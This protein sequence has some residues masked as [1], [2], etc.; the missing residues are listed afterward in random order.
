MAVSTQFLGWD[1]PVIRKVVAFL[2]PAEMTGL[3]DLSGDLIVVPTRQAGRRLREALAVECAKRDT[4]VMSVRV[5]THNALLHMDPIDQPMANDCLVRAVW[6][7]LLMDYD[8]SELSG[9]FP[10]QVGTQDFAWA[11]QMADVLQSLRST[12]ADGGCR[13]S[14]VPRMLND[15]CPEP[16][17]WRDLVALET[18]YLDQLTKCG[19]LDPLIVRI[20]QAATVCLPQ[21][22]R[23]VVVA[24]VPDPT[25]LVVRAL[26]RIAIDLPVVVLVHADPE[27][28]QA[29][30]AWGRPRQSAWCDC[31]IEV[32]DPQCNIV[33]A[34]TPADQ[35][36][37]VKEVLAQ[38]ADQFGP[39]DVAVGV[40]DSDVIPPLIEALASHG[41]PADDPA[42]QSVSS[43]PLYHLL[44]AY[45]RL[46]GD[47]SFI[48]LSSFL[49]HPDV[50]EMFWQQ[51]S[52]QTV[53]LLEQADRFQNHYLPLSF[54]DVL[55]RLEQTRQRRG[56]DY[57]DFRKAVAWVQSQIDLFDLHRP[58]ELI[59]QL[60]AQVYA[61]RS[62]CQTDTGDE[63]MM[64]VATVVNEV[65]DQIGDPVLDA[66]GL[67]KHQ[68][69]QLLLDQLSAQAYYIARSEAIIDLEGWLELP[70]VDAP[71]LVVTGMNEGIVPDSR[72]SDLFLPD[73]L[74]LRL[75]L[76]SDQDWATRDAY[77]MRTLIE[78][79]S[80][81]GRICFVVGKTNAQGD[82]LKPSRLLFRCCDEQLPT[83]A[84]QL[85]GHGASH[86]ED[87]AFQVSFKLRVQPPND[88]ATSAINPNQISVTAIRDYLACPFRYYLSHVLG[89]KT[90]DDQKR[91]LDALDFGS[92][93]HEALQVLGWTQSLRQSTDEDKLSGALC[94]QADRWIKKRFGGSLPFPVVIQL[95]A[96]KQR[97]TAAAR[98][99]VALNHE[100]W[101][102]IDSEYPITGLVGG[103]EVRGRIDRID[104]HRK[105]G[106]FR[107]LDYKTSDTAKP[108]ANVHLGAV[109]GHVGAYAKVAVG[110]RTKSWGD[111]QLPLYRLMLEQKGYTESPISVGYF[112][113]PKAVGQTG[114][115]VWETLDDDL[116]VSADHCAEGVV[117]DILAKRFW[118]PAQQ[119]RYDEFQS[120]FCSDDEACI[121]VNEFKSFMELPG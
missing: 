31:F 11:V 35:C 73:S 14:D 16:E 3:V 15:D 114:V 45:G 44:N 83:R 69:L 95:E 104:R 12:L 7:R 34:A 4:A 36:R 119:V 71:V 90:L 13:I 80:N 81:D 61:G 117:G 33:L 94:D 30:D 67:G 63:S 8:L 93:V 115:E 82:P 68:T 84:K 65:L 17:R 49:R 75:G 23:R 89:M 77:L 60:L 42:G 9:L 100:G 38:E 97:L 55:N 18:Q 92:L 40:P 56:E 37:L 96:A 79:R 53:A 39:A 66:I 70:W 85:F 26:D 28:A 120:L 5:V 22:V 20:E 57:L 50:L 43:H 19:L 88:V 108:P 32:P 74:R 48:A 86:Q 41:L 54:D 62:L 121:N 59:R 112:N 87:A 118:P 2:L 103:L 109:R 46:L 113:L 98:V 58:D 110:R 27:M 107:V 21:K 116:L 111:L 52:I 106:I 101:E 10:T 24:A 6:A 1:E 91:S 102:M 64:A 72:L 47:R 25:P 76:H 105:S 78:A 29:F 51:Q 99:H